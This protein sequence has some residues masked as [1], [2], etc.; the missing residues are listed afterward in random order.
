MKPVEEAMEPYKKASF[1]HEKGVPVL[2]PEYDCAEMTKD[3]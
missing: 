3:P 2:H 1:R